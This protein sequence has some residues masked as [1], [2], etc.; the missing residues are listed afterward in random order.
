MEELASSVDDCKATSQGGLVNVAT[1]SCDPEEF[2]FQYLEST[3]HTESMAK[4]QRSLVVPGSKDQSTKEKSGS[5]N[6][7][8][9]KSEDESFARA[10]QRELGGLRRSRHIT[11]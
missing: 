4:S 9:A 11:I 3:A 8:K 6:R 5:K 10:L 7:L 1:T 2:S